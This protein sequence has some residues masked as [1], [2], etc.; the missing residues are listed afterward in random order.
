MTLTYTGKC[1]KQGCILIGEDYGYVGGPA[2]YEVLEVTKSV[3]KLKE[4]SGN[5]AI[6][7]IRIHER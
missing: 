2:K 6:E 7:E 5:K 4:L 1:L 3:V